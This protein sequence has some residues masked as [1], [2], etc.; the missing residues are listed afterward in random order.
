MANL[1]T[2]LELIQ[3]KIQSKIADA[4]KNEV[5]DVVR[6]IEQEEIEKEVFEKYSPKKYL[7]RSVGGLDDPNNMIANTQLRADGSVLL[8]VENVTMSNPD[9]LPDGKEPFKIAG[10]IEYG[11][12][13]NGYGYDYPREGAAY[14]E[15]RPFIRSTAER[16]KNN[17][18]IIEAFKK[19][20]RRRGLNVK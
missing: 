13:W 12:G 17:P 7:R 4:M 18:E 11:H 3:Q 20:L 14:M 15:A 19:G 16:L 1:R 10:V 6:K 5:A 8:T 2:Q 9:Y